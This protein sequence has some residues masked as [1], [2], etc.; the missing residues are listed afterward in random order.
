MRSRIE[1]VGS[2]HAFLPSTKP[3]NFIPGDL[4]CTPTPW[5]KYKKGR[6]VLAFILT[7][8]LP[9]SIHAKPDPRELIL[10]KVA[11]GA[12]EIRVPPGTYRLSQK[13]KV[14]LT[15]QGIKDTVIDCTGVTWIGLAHTAMIEMIDCHNV[16]IKGLAVDYD[17][18]PFTQGFITHVGPDGDWT[19]E[20]IDGYPAVGVL[21]NADVDMRIQAYDAKSDK[22]VNALRHGD[23][24]AIEKT[25]ERTFRIMGG[26]IRDGKVGDIAIF[27]TLLFNQKIGRKPG[28]ILTKNCQGLIFED[29]VLRS[30]QVMGFVS[31]GDTDNTYLRCILDRSPMADD[32]APRGMKRLRSLNADGFHIKKNIVG[33]QIKDCTARYMGDD[34]V[35]ISGMYSLVTEGN[36]TEI[37]ILASFFEDPDIHPGDT[38]EMMSIEG[39][40][41]PDARVVSIR[42]DGRITPE[43]S[44][45]VRKLNLVPFY[46]DPS[47]PHMKKAFRV[48]LDRQPGLK[49]GDVV[50][51]GE[52]VGNGFR[53]EGNTFGP[54]R[55]RPVLIKASHGV[56][57]GN[58][59]TGAE[60]EGV[61]G[62][63]CIGP[64]YF[65]MEGSAGSDIRIEN[66]TIENGAAPAIFLG[67]YLN[68]PGT[69]LPP[70]SR[71][72]IRIIGNTIRNNSAPGIVVHGCTDL[73]IKNNHLQLTGDSNIS[74]MDLRK[75]KELTELDN[76]ISF[77]KRASAK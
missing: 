8:L 53:I 75:V 14:F 46:R 10:E 70:E 24:V 64:E 68:K 51:S 29:V 2:N 73:T 27:N 3:M 34:C 62:A 42:E 15:L 49:F 19:V 37:R 61:L 47:S 50:I 20:I 65:W 32:Y 33:P 5:V 74:A 4:P 67:G 7:L 25:G 52:R 35:N 12:K 66:N 59:I 44:A 9:H 23:G 41:I 58:T 55:S 38:L 11:Q 22:L 13:E 17:P 72:G 57:S 76:Q 28:A 31:E 43:E 60:K 56:V 21:L 54:I 16:T 39:R 69:P 63:I 26:R 30:S 71:S 45:K 18:L 6:W 77:S 1:T 40:R 48:V 36:G